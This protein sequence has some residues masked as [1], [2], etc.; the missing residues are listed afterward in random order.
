MNASN[1]FTGNWVKEVSVVLSDFSVCFIA[2]KALRI[3]MV[4]NAL[5]TARCYLCSVKIRPEGSA[6]ALL[7]SRGC[8]KDAREVRIDDCRLNKQ[9]DACA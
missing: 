1:I 5:G 8:G 3:D 7:Q 9:D 4:C 2:V 6:S